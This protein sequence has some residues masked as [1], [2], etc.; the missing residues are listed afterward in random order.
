MLAGKW[1]YGEAIDLPGWKTIK[2]KELDH[3]IIVLARA[4]GQKYLH[5]ACQATR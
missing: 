1:R 2:Y 4:D 5:E 3:D